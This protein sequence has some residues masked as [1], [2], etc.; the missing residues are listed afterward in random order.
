MDEL[1]GEKIIAIIPIY[2]ADRGNSTL[3]YTRKSKEVINKTIK[4]V[5]KNLCNHYHLDIRQCNNYY[6]KFILNKNSIPTPFSREDIFIQLKVRNPIGKDDGAKGYFRMDSILEFEEN[7]G[8]S[9]IRMENK[10][11]LKCL[12]SLNAIKKQMKNGEI[13]KKMYKEKEKKGDSDFKKDRNRPVL[14][15]DFKEL[16]KK[17]EQLIYLIM[18]RG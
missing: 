8:F 2:L 10:T 18:E 17:V 6:K 11:E 4:T 16:D 1:I 3:I 15:G 9:L 12:C 14:Y 5:F 13:I 7:Q